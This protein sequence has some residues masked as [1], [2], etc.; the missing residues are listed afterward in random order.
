MKIECQ[1]RTDGFPG[2]PKDQ[3]FMGKKR[4]STNTEGSE[5]NGKTDL[6]VQPFLAD[7][8][9]ANFPNKLR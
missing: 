7:L 8:A 6:K 3:L 5:K 2:G 9:G 1:D 4:G